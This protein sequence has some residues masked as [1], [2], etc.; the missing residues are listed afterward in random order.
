[1]S[2]YD[3]RSMGERLG[4]YEP[5]LDGMRALAVLAV[6]L[7]HASP[8]RFPGGWVGVDVF[9]VLSG[10]L[11]TSILQKENSAKGTIDFKNFYY[12]RI[13]R[14]APAFF[15][16][17]ITDLIISICFSNNVKSNL[18]AVAVSAFYLMNLNRSFDIL[19]S[20]HL[21]H[22][23]SLAMEEQFYIF[24]PVIFISAIR[25]KPLVIVSSLLVIVIGWRVYLVL[26]GASPDRIYNG[27]DTHSDAL[28]VGCALSL[29]NLNKNLEI[30]AKN[31]VLL[32]IALLVFIPA[33]SS[34]NA[35]FSQIVGLSITAF[36]SA[37]IIV[38]ALQTGILKRFLS[39]KAL[40]F[41]GR[42]SYGWYLWH[43]LIYSAGME[44]FD[45]FTG[46]TYIFVF[47][48]YPIAV[49]SYFF[50]ERPFLKLKS[51]IDFAQRQPDEY[52]S[53]TY[54]NS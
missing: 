36:T 32:P 41:T 22:T 31:Y 30:I 21:G 10:F 43:Y 29:L 27:F 25:W 11:I 40:V 28:I 20:G 38:A 45:K 1:M 53:K 34:E 18:I 49:L 16:V 35:Y 51:R 7:F 6:V 26:N 48:A 4:K 42:I 19:P 9:F 15:L 44:Y 46:M 8:A 39:T 2:I 13:L 47:A 54:Y 24:W 33:T 3:N 12:K 14:L 52:Q 37:W 17:L 50:V 23:W 5:S